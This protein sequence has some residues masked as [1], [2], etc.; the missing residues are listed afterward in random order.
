MTFVK[1]KLA[2]RLAAEKMSGPVNFYFGAVVLLSFLALEAS[3]NSQ[4]SS[5]E[6]SR[7]SKETMPTVRVLQYNT[8]L[9]ND[10]V[11]FVTF[12]DG[13][14]ERLSDIPRA[15]KQCS[16]LDILV[17]TEVF[18]TE[19]QQLFDSL[20][21]VWPHRTRVMQSFWRYETGG[22]FVLSKNPI[23]EQDYVV[24]DAASKWDKAVAKGVRYCL[25]TAHGVRVHVFATHMQP[26]YDHQL[27]RDT[28]IRLRQLQTMRDF[29][30]SK[31]IGPQDLVV[32]AGDFNIATTS[33]EYKRMLRVLGARGFDSL[34]N[35]SSVTP[36]NQLS[37]MSY[38]S[39]ENGCVD[40]YRELHE[41]P[42]CMDEL[43]DFVFVAK[44]SRR[45]RSVKLDTWTSFKPTRVLCA[46]MP[47]LRRRANSKCRD[48][49]VQIR[50]LSDH[51]PVVCTIDVRA[52]KSW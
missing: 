46:D 22:I 44:R 31:D 36:S 38:E 42:C 24:F 13:K 14:E 5:I 49:H 23:L 52:S 33:P 25:T 3:A 21:S 29:V 27:D 1:K 39:A 17:L 2:T 10:I 16:N 48:V 4:P 19:R 40:E 9:R 30:D 26:T 11:P 15:L 7:C 20:R 43:I 47:D 35:I 45:V 6:L 8:F 18:H 50:D 34:T 51:F 41:C 12:K 37:G 32:M 28:K